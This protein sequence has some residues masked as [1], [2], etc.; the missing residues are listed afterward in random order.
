MIE[1]FILIIAFAYFYWNKGR[2]SRR[3]ELLAKIP[4]P[5]SVPILKHT[6]HFINKSPS[7]VLSLVS[8]FAV[9]FGQIFTFGFPIG[10]QI[11][12]ADP[13]IV[14]KILSNQKVIDKA[15][16]Y[17]FLLGWLGTGLL[18]STGKK[19][20]SR[21]KIITPTFHFK[22]LENFVEI[23]ERHGN[24][25]VEKLKQLQGQDVNV[26]LPISHYALDVICGKF[27]VNY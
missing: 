9:E 20:H 14:E 12:I 11:M 26:C 15:V 1:F 24:V 19:W 25:F 4:S 13:K 3:D 7:E 16:D 2:N 18:I 10:G 23:M 17:D 6:L 22:I 21:R 5:K 27:T 8:D